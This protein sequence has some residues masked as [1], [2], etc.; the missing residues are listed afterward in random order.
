[1]KN[2]LESLTENE[3][4]ELA[5]SAHQR[6]ERLAKRVP[7]EQMVK[8][9]DSYLDDHGWTFDELM[10]PQGHVRRH[11]RQP[12]SPPRFRDPSSPQRTW[13]GI[14][15]KPKWIIAKELNGEP[16]EDLRLG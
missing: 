14:G 16:I 8:M 6:A 3:L 2:L 4:R 7:R 5:A 12:L 10:N 15:R 11:T 13:A 1:M 9:L